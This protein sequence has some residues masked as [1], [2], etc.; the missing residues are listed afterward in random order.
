MRRLLVLAVLVVAVAAGVFAGDGA[1]L[2]DTPR[3]YTLTEAN[4]A[5]LISADDLAGNGCVPAGYDA[6]TCTPTDF[7]WCPEHP[8]GNPGLLTRAMLDGELVKVSNTTE[9]AANPADV[10]V[11]IGAN[12]GGPPRR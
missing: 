2:G 6:I 12:V 4:N 10:R 1:R 7:P 3:A 9:C 5:G 8:S 11:L